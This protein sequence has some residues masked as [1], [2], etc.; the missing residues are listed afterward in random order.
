MSTTKYIVSITFPQG[1][2]PMTPAELHEAIE[3]VVD[4]DATVN[5]EAH[6]TNGTDTR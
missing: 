6:E 2:Q 5:V 3:E 1:L 4:M